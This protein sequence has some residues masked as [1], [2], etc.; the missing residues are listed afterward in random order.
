MALRAVS[1]L[2]PIPSECRS[3][4][5]LVFDG[6]MKPELLVRRIRATRRQTVRITPANLA[7][8]GNDDAGQ[9]CDPSDSQSQ[10]FRTGSRPSA[11]GLT[12]LCSSSSR[13][14]FLARRRQRTFH[15]DE[16]GLCLSSNARADREP[17][18]RALPGSPKPGRAAADRRRE[19]DVPPLRGGLG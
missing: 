3:G 7:H 9:G 16:C 1:G 13:R 6:T 17:S 2:R 18:L 4:A 11:V 19:S 12:P 15:S 8:R 10:P 5:D 14:E